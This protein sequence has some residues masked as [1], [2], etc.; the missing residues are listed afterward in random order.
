MTVFLDQ[1]LIVEPRLPGSSISLR[2]AIGSNMDRPLL[3]TGQDTRPW[4]PKAECTFGLD[5]MCHLLHWRIFD[6]ENRVHFSL[7]RTSGSAGC[8]TRRLPM[9]SSA[10][11]TACR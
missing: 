2:V 3:D 10:K 4:S 8:A 1:R 7:T 9:I 5:L 6:A 11:R